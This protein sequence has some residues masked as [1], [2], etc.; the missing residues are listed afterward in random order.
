MIKLKLKLKLKSGQ[1][2]KYNLAD[3]GLQL[4]P[5]LLQSF[6]LWFQSENI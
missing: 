2:W 1:I 4:H 5:C 3:K 6:Q